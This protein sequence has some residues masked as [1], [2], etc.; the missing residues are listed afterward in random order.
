MRRVLGRSGTEVSALGIGTWA[1]GG[2][3]FSGD[4]PLGWGAVD[5]E[6]SV[7]A[8][9]RAVE[10]GATFVDTADAYCTGHSE[11]IIA[12]ALG[13]EREKLVWAT[14]WGNTYDEATRQLTGAD[15]SPAYA[16]RALEASLLRLRTDRVD[17]WQLHLSDL[18]PALAEDLV[19]TCEDL[20][21]E[22]KIRAYAWST[23]DPARAGV[24]AAGPHCAAVQHTLNV[25]DDAPQM[26]ALC[27]EHDLASINRSPL[28][29]GL[30]SERVT[31]DTTVPPGDI[32]YRQPDWL[33]WFTD[34]R[35]TPEF[36][37]RRDAVR[38]VL[39]SGG[40]TLAQ[41]ALAWIWARSPRTIPIP[42]C[43]TVAQVEENVGS[44][45]YGPLTSDELAT[46]EAVLRPAAP[47]RHVSHL[48][49]P[50]PEGSVQLGA[51]SCT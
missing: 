36:L 3:M 44:M 31:A 12:R 18:D 51:T 16:R 4:Q 10:L 49:T 29:M 28:A 7:R 17:L 5:D 32:R 21:G 37:Q 11:R 20:M 39:T 19:A 45:R 24:F 8:L 47:Q 22:G 48:A 2:A 27:E 15:P 9:R 38:D 25:L 40:R 33:R 46:V 35:P 42:G 30:L 13:A 43:R 1:I 26:L 34:G 50:G 41:G 23:D 14:K 6:E